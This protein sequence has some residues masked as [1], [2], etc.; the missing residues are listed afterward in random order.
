MALGKLDNLQSLSRRSKGAKEVLVLD[1]AEVVPKDGQLSRMVRNSRSSFLLK[2][3][4][5]SI[6]FRKVSVV[7]VP[8]NRLAYRLRRSSIKK[9]RT[10]WTRQPAS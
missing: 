6:G 3:P 1:T 2:I 8:V 4:T 5:V 9:T 7:G 10:S